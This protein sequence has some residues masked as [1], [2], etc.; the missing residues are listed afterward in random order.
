MSPQMTA[1]DVW[2]VLDLFAAAGARAWIDGGWAVDACLGEQ[3]RP[4]GDLD[5]V[6]QK[7][8]LQAAEAALRNA[9]FRDVQRNDTRPWNFVLGDENGREID[10]HVIERDGEG[11]GIYGPPEERVVFPS[12]SLTGMGTIAGRPVACTTPEW[13]VASHAGYEPD[14]N[15]WR[16][17]SR[18]CE[19]FG[20]P[21][22]EEYRRRF[23]STFA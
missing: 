22:P 13:L 1:E 16:D 14:D 4:H 23:D 11:H 6:V 20:M 8:H 7:R 10:F 15:D 5:I 3:T 18:L 19:T 17:V 12:G 2:A 9:G 21:V